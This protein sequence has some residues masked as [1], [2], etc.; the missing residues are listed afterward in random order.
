MPFSE[1]GIEKGNQ[2]LKV[3]PFLEGGTEKGNQKE[4]V[5]LKNVKLASNRTDKQSRITTSIKLLTLI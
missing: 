5:V 2:N 3:M 4:E 1:V